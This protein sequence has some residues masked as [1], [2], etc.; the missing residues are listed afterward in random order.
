MRWM[1]GSCSKTECCCAPE[2]GR[3]YGQ[4]LSWD[5]VHVLIQSCIFAS[6]AG[7]VCSPFAL[8]S[9]YHLYQLYIAKFWYGGAAGVALMGDSEAAPCWIRASS[10]KL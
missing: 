2:E 8:G 5:Y 9:S 10:R 1:K 7:C 4:C 3:A 6:T